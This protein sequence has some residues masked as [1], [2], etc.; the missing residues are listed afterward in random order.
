MLPRQLWPL[1][2]FRSRADNT[3]F[4]LDSRPASDSIL[5]ID[6][7]RLTFHMT[8]LLATSL[9][10]ARVRPLPQRMLHSWLETVSV[11][12]LFQVLLRVR[13]RMRPLWF[14]L[15][16]LLAQAFSLAILQAVLF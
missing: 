5:T 12:E 4:N 3:R 13:E 11:F 6:S 1:L 2:P 9:R 8:K 16:L 7:L 14:S 15:E 10:L